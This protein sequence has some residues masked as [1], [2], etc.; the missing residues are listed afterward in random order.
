MIFRLHIAP[1]RILS[2]LMLIAFIGLATSEIK[3]QTKYTV[4]GTVKKNKKKLDGAVVTLT[5]GSALANQ[6]TTST[7]GRFSV[8][9]DMNAE[10]TLSVTKPG[11][12]TK[13]FYFNTK[14][15][16]EERAKEE[17]GGQDIEVS[18]FELPKDP[19]VV[20]QIN[21]ILSQP[22]AKFFYDDKIKE[23][24]YDKAY[25]QSMQDALAKLAQVEKEANAKAEEQAKQQQQLEAAAASQ[26]QAA[27][28]KADAAFAKKDYAGARAAYE[29]ALSV[30]KGEPYPLEKIKEIEK[31]LADAAKNAQVENDYKAA[32]AKADAAFTAKNFDFAKTNYN[33]ALKLKPTEA[34]PKTKLAE[35]DAA[36]AK[37][38]AE[39]EL[40][41][42]YDAALAKGDKAFTA[43]DYANAKV[44][45]N[46]AL[47]MKAAEK[48][49]KD[50]IAEIDKVLADLAA[51]EKAE[52]E[53]NEKYSAAIAK[54]DKAFTAKDYVAA[55]AG[56]TE[57]SGFKP[58]EAYP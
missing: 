56:Y 9:L 45:Y 16:P 17:F 36:I 33:D 42:K 24:E 27:I 10:Y 53:L 44:G 5:K 35:I 18:I 50:K 11:H 58:A 46:E 22:I 29:D 19:G 20:S 23:I 34:Y 37:Q 54:A 57:A 4:A 40:N 3:A 2:I 30:K 12:I 28:A 38:G 7:N 41:A 51:K 15:I 43:K 25:T 13:K 26:Y 1:K 32:I 48:Y 31:L 49:P 21:S 14:G 52:K 39:K 55:K 47:A 6:I 8:L